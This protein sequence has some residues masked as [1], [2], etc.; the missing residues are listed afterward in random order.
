VA[1]SFFLVLQ[2]KEIIVIETKQILTFGAHCCVKKARRFSRCET[3]VIASN[4]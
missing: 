1:F 2:F 3:A 4:K